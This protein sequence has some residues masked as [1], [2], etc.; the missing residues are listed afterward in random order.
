MSPQ[1]EDPGHPVPREL[2]RAFPLGLRVGT[3]GLV[4]LSRGLAVTVTA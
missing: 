3:R 1:G 2:C 4:L